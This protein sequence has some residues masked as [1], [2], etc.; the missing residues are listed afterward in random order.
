[1]AAVVVAIL[2][3]AGALALR[4]SDWS[5]RAPNARGAAPRVLMS[6]ATPR[7]QRELFSIASGST[8]VSAGRVPPGAHATVYFECIGPGTLSIRVGA[9]DPEVSTPCGAPDQFA[10]LGVSSDAQIVEVSAP[11]TDRWR[12]EGFASAH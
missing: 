1:L 9:L 3:A 7:G 11:P 4:G 2:V 10:E 5:S 6:I 8:F 12:V